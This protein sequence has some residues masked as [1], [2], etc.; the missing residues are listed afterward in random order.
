MELRKFVTTALLDIVNGVVDAQKHSAG[1]TIVPKSNNTNYS[2]AETGLTPLQKIDFHVSIRI[3]ESKGKKGQL[4]VMSSLVGAGV[5]G[6][7]S[8]ESENTTTLKF[9][10]PIRLPIQ[11]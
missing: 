1:A 10:V 4:G 5:A 9:S 2:V 6:S 3:D 7:S 8:T 11:S